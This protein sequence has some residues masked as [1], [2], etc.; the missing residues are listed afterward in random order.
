MRTFM[1]LAMAMILALVF[2]GC[3]KKKKKD[4]T[5]EARARKSGSVVMSSKGVKMAKC[6]KGKN[7]RMVTLDLNRD[8]RRDRWLLLGAGNVKICHEMDTDFDGKPDLSI[9][10][11]D[12]GITR[13]VVWWDLDYDGVWDQVMY[14]RPDGTKKRVEIRPYPKVKGK[15]ASKEWKPLVW[16]Y[17]RN[18]KGKGT[19]IDR[20]EMDKDRNGYKDYWERYEGGVL[21]EVSWANAGDTDEKPKHWIEAPEE[22]KDKGYSGTDENKKV[23]PKDKKPKARK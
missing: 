2:V 12:D 16:K 13:A 23:K 11:F 1:N 6:K 20:V 3:D 10:Y 15:K 19:V 18:I 7:A 14:N 8:K 21:R 5:P 4:T 9:R 17:Y 22:G